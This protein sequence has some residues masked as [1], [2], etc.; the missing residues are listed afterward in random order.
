MLSFPSKVPARHL[1]P[2]LA[3]ALFFVQLGLALS[4][5]PSIKLMQ[6]IICRHHYGVTSDEELI[7]EMR[8]VEAVQQ[9]LNTISIGIL[10]SVIVASKLEQPENMKMS[11]SFV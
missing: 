11:D 2:F 10:I 8:H 1:L 9:E 5:L 4:D 3:V 6:D 7:E